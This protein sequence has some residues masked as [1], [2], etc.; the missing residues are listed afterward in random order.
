MPCKLNG[1][2][3]SAGDDG[4]GSVYANESFLVRYC[5]A[6]S[7]VDLATFFFSF[8]FDAL[9]DKLASKRLPNKT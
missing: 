7:D 9:Y 4:G 1:A 5:R 6:A 8:F 2:S 3:C